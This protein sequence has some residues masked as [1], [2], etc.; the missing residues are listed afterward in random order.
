MSREVIDAIKELA[1]EKGIDS[2][3]LMSALEDALLSA[4]RKK[5]ARLA[6]HAPRSTTTPRTSASSS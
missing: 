1:D 6:T 3:S 2:E 5:P 4:Y